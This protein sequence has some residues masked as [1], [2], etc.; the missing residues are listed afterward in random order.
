MHLLVP[1]MVPVA[2]THAE[3]SSMIAMA[4]DQDAM[5]MREVTTV[6]AAAATLAVSA[7]Q[8]TSLLGAHHR[9]A[10]MT[11]GTREQPRAGTREDPGTTG[12]AETPHRATAD[13]AVAKNK[14]S[15]PVLVVCLTRLLSTALALHHRLHRQNGNGTADVALVLRTMA[16]DAVVKT[17][18]V[19]ARLGARTARREM[20]GQIG[21]GD[22]RTRLL[23]TRLR[24]GGAGGLRMVRARLRGCGIGM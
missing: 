5:K 17:I 3:I 16:A 12:V 7:G 4:A 14:R 1:A 2:L 22:M 10:W 11:V 19:V 20:M 13:E 9:Q 21:R 6:T 8:T 24:G 23:L 18:E 15:R